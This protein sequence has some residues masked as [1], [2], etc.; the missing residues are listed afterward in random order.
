MAAVTV[1]AGVK[2]VGDFA[3]FQAELRQLQIDV[4]S[5]PKMAGISQSIID[6][7]LE[8]YV[9]FKPSG[10]GGGNS[11]VL[12]GM[13]GGGTAAGILLLAG[14]IKDLTKQSKIVSMTQ[15]AVAK[16]TGLLID[17]ILIPFLPL[18]TYG[19]I[20]L[21]RAITTFGAEWKKDWKGEAAEII[22]D[23]LMLNFLPVLKMA[24]LFFGVDITDYFHEFLDASNG[25]NL[26]ITEWN[27]F[28][29][30]PLGNIKRAW[31][32]FVSWVST[33]LSDTWKG[34]YNYLLSIP[35]IGDAMRLAGG[36]HQ[37]LSIPEVT[38]DEYMAMYAARGGQTTEE[39]KSSGG[40]GTPGNPAPGVTVMVYI[41]GKFIDPAELD[42]KIENKVGN[43]NW[44]GLKVTGAWVD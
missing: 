17:M 21:F 34:L 42:Q 5:D 41:D 16:A 15:D 6:S 26:F 1:D 25:W 3:S 11:G 7:I 31:D 43:M 24:E 29:T 8:Q 22:V 30:D 12:A 9:K 35:I 14:A 23:S 19:I 33:G 20:N 40:I 39:P 4:A 32:G 27:N 36:K 18:I 38:N 10:A 44:N 37:N 13:V 28:W 2:L